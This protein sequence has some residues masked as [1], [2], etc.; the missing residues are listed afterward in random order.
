MLPTTLPFTAPTAV[1]LTPTYFLY[2]LLCKGGVI[3]AGITTDVERRYKEHCAG[4]GAK[5]TRSR[6]PQRLLCQAA[7]GDRSSAQ[8]AEYAVKQLPKARKV[9]FVQGMTHA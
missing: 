1:T 7:I 9:A 5:F 6:P 4:K 2:L 8:K 3:Y